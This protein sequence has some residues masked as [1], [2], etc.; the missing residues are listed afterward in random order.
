MSPAALRPPHAA[1]AENTE[2]QPR[3]G[4]AYVTDP[5]VNMIRASGLTGM[6]FKRIWPHS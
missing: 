4:P 2:A 6:E 3:G 5:F 1:E